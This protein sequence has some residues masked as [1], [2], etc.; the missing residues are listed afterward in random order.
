MYPSRDH[1]RG[2]MMRTGDYVGDDFCRRRV[3]NRRLQHAHDRS[4]TLPQPNLFANDRGIALQNCGPETMRKDASPGSLGA[5]V[6]HIQQP[7]Q[8]WV[9]THYV[10]ISAADNSGPNFTGLPKSNHGEAYR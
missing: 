9:Q 10:E 8:D 4:G 6:T 2:K 7:P 3:R 1:G 5:V